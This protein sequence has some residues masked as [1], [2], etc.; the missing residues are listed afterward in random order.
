MSMTWLKASNCYQDISLTTTNVN[1]VV[2]LEE[3][4]IGNESDKDSSSGHHKHGYQI[5]QQFVQ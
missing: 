1:L 5:S 3:I 4:S 2:A